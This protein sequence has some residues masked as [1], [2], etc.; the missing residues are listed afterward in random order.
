MKSHLF[1]QFSEL[2]SNGQGYNSYQTILLV[3][4]MVVWTYLYVYLAYRG[5]K[6]KFVQIPLILA[7]GNIVWEFL[8]GFVFQSEFQTGVLI[9]MGAAFLIDLTIFYGILKYM[10]IHISVKFYAN[11]L[12]LLALLGLTLF[13]ITWWTF[14][15]SGM[16]TDAGGASGNLLNALI[17]IFWVNQVFT[18]KDINLLSIRLGWV[19]LIADIPIAFFMLS[20]FPENYFAYSI[21]FISVFFD[22]IYIYL[23]YQR[24]AKKGIFK[25]YKLN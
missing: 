13:V 18:I 3:I 25:N 21:T 19:K 2:L 12:G 5:I 10:K 9:G 16:D 15:T 22:A 14:K 11:N 23:F 4:G 20:V 6:T 17:A 8:W 24:K 7:C 1:S